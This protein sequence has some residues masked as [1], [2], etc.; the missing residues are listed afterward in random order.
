MTYQPIQ[1]TETQ[2]QQ[3]QEDGFLILENFL[4]KDLT[5]QLLDRFEPMFAGEFEVALA[6]WFKFARYYQADV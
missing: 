3:F 1:L 4:P 5:Q 2:L 6:A